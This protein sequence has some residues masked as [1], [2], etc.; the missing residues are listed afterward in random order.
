MVDS[1]HAIDENIK[2][3]IESSNRFLLPILSDIH[4][5]AGINNP[6]ASKYTVIATFRVIAFTCKS[7]AIC[8][9]AVFSAEP[10]ISSIS[11]TK[12]IV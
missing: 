1:P 10:S 8:G 2:P 4:P 6:K 9:S 3:V 12:P 5:D 11:I 7:F